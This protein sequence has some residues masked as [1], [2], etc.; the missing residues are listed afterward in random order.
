MSSRDLWTVIGR[1]KSDVSFRDRLFPH[2]D[3]T[4]KD[5]GYELSDA[6]LV[7]AK[8]ALDDGMENYLVHTDFSYGFRL[9]YPSDW[10]KL[11]LAPNMVGFLSPPESPTDIF[12]DNVVVNVGETNLSL[13]EQ[14][15]SEMSQLPSLFPNWAS[16]QPYGVTVANLPAERLQL[17]G[18]MGPDLRNNQPE[19]MLT[20]MTVVWVMKGKRIYRIEYTAEARAYAKFMPQFQAMLESFELS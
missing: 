19:M 7:Q 3:Q 5:E 2:F 6:E 11:V 15:D 4:V 17:A 12:Q 16:G 9:K 20:Q 18:Q 13:R 8:H 1:A 10:R 14:V